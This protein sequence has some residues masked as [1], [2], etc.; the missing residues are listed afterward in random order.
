MRHFFIDL[1][2]TGPAGLNGLNQL[3]PNDEIVLM[4]SRNTKLSIEITKVLHNIKNVRFYQNKVQHTNALDFQMIYWIGYISGCANVIYNT[5]TEFIIIS[6]DKGYDAIKQAIQYLDLN[7]TV[8]RRECIDDYFNP[9]DTNDKKPVSDPAI[10]PETEPVLSQK[11]PKY[12]SINITPTIENIKART[13]GINKQSKTASILK[14]G[15]KLLKKQTDNP[16]INTDIELIT[17]RLVG[18]LKAPEK[19][20]AMDLLT[21]YFTEKQATNLY[22]TIL[23]TYRAISKKK[24]G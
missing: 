18:Y 23:R 2:N 14:A 17:G 24:K 10:E 4:Y 12:S 6:N 9:T 15:L 5:S 20:K 22:I 16:D 11:K 21:D 19:D 8:T 1:E 13:S 3:D 7:V